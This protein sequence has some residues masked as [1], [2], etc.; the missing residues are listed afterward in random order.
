MENTFLLSLVCKT[1]KEADELEK[2]LRSNWAID[3]V[4]SAPLVFEVTV[5]AY[6]AIN[7]L[8]LVKALRRTT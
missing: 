1:K 2:S 6:E 7:M 8:L 3:V 5:S 4:Q